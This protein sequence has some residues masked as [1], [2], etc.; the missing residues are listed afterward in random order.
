[1]PTAKQRAASR[2]NAQKSTGPRTSA[3][4]A[5]SRFNALKHG[6]YAVHQI[7]FDE[8][9][10]DLAELAAEYHE[11]H[12]PA[13]ADQRFLVDT[14]VHNEWRLRR[15]RR[16]E[17]ELWQTVSNT[18]L[19]KNIE[20]TITC[21]SGDAFAT[22]SVTFERLQRVVNSLE[23]AWHRALKE[24]QRLQAEAKVGPAPFSANAPA[25]APANPGPLSQQPDAAAT[26]APPSQPEQSKP[27][28]ASSASFCDNPKTPAPAA[29]QSPVVDP[30]A[31]PFANPLAGPNAPATPSET[32]PPTSDPTPK[33]PQ[34]A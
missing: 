9:A 13:N 7:M 33:P 1:M 16:V 20:T 19:V 8:K 3:G 10:E 29:T 31:P 11:H 21:T 5:I 22:D 24:L 12:S 17:A 2:A 26:P 34:T 28:P 14:L 6:I 23:R 4:K 32:Q 15:T 30:D 18:F 25:N 27:A